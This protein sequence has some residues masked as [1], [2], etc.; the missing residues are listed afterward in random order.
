MRMTR[1]RRGSQEFSWQREIR[2]RQREQDSLWSL[3]VRW[4]R[5]RT[6]RGTV[7]DSAKQKLAAAHEGLRHLIDGYGGNLNETLVR[8]R[9]RGLLEAV[10]VDR[11]GRLFSPRWSG[12]RAFGP[13][14]AR[15]LAWME[16]A[17]QTGAQARLLSV[18][19]VMTLAVGLRLLDLNR[20]GFNSDEAVYSGQAGALIGDSVMAG[21][22]SVFRAHPLLLQVLLGGLF[23]IVGVSDLAARLF[24]SLFFGVGSIALTYL[25]ASRLYGH[26]VGIAASTIMAVLPYHVLISRQVLLDSPLT[27]F[28]LLTMWFTARGIDDQ[29][30][31]WMIWAALSAGLATATKETGVLLL[32]V[33][34]SF[35]IATGAW[36]RIP[37]ARLVQGLA[38]FAVLA[39]P[40]PLSRMLLAPHSGPSYLLW[41]ISRPPNHEAEYF[42]RVLWDFGGMAFLTLA[43]VGLIRMVTRSGE[44]RNALLL[45]WIGVFGAFFQIWPTKLFP[46]LMPL[47]PVLCISAAL[48]LEACARGI[49]AA[50]RARKR[51]E[52]IHP[53][54]FAAAIAIVLAIYLGGASLSTVRSGPEA[55]GQP[56][57]TDL[58]VQDFA[59]GREFGLWAKEHTPSDARFLTIGPSIGNVLRFYG[60]RESVALS[61]SP[62]PRFRNPAYVPVR[63]PDLWLRE[64]GLHYIVWDFYSADRSAFYN[65]RLMH[66]VRKYGGTA[67]YAVYEEPNG[68][69]VAAPGAPPKGVTPRILVYDAIGG[70]PLRRSAPTSE[71][72]IAREQDSLATPNVDLD[73]LIPRELGQ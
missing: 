20:I 13:L 24:V 10:L 71:A 17:V 8:D 67:V 34:G 27:F 33:I 57:H 28:V 56:F 44:K 54:T 41:Q 1:L 40:Y 18:A 25:L 19:A 21:F 45:L 22:F 32:A 36:R 65:A 15:A 66:Y 35:L 3:V 6:D 49:G 12:G 73:P 29:S 16:T 50:L 4:L 47:I 48:G 68:S 70:D 38:L 26:R 64:S 37:P 9:D 72:M 55:L 69:L 62:D 7:Y 30:G 60:H 42:L 53:Q 52:G 59:G 31:R 63:N 14:G 43:L 46:Y 5:R 23:S 2:R 11:A 61:V 51:L 39:A 58:E